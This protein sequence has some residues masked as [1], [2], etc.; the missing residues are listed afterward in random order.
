MKYAELKK[1]HDPNKKEKPPRE[2][3]KFLHIKK[4]ASKKLRHKLLTDEDRQKLTNTIAGCERNIR[5]IYQNKEETK[6]R[7]PGKG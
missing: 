7:K 4:K 5:N 3:V 6:K 1:P 2:I